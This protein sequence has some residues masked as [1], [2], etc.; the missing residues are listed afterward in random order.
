MVYI[1][2]YVGV[3]GGENEEITEVMCSKDGNVK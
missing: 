2:D 3:G 1:E